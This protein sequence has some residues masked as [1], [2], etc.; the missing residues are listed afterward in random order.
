M[1]VSVNP[2]AVTA[3]VVSAPEVS[4]P[5]DPLIDAEQIRFVAL[6]NGTGKTTATVGFGA[7]PP[8]PAVMVNCSSC[9]LPETA[10][11]PL[12]AAP[13]VPHPVEGVIFAAVCATPVAEADPKSPTQLE[14][15]YTAV[16]AVSTLPPRSNAVPEL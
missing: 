2:V 5:I 16:V 14:Q 1:A 12:P 3:D 4:D 13:V 7:V 6:R 8:P 10:E 15:V 9:E 11:T